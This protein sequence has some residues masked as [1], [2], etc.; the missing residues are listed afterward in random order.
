MQ[1]NKNIKKELWTTMITPFAETGEIDYTA[2]GR[3]MAWYE[4]RGVDHFFTV[5]LSS[6]M[7]QLSLQERVDLARFVKTHA[8]KGHKV[9][10]AGHTTGSPEEQLREFGPIIGTGVDVI[11]L[12]LSLLA[13]PE[14]SDEIVIH[15]MEKY[16]PSLAGWILASMNAL[17][18]INGGFRTTF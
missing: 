7:L 18:P 14:E 16:Y 6:E 11:V 13:A 10:A 2:L 15:R 8:G 1:H 3:L 5:C 9:A 4:E 17:C 12:V